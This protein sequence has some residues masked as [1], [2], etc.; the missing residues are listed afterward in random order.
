MGTLA[1]TCGKQRDNTQAFPERHLETARIAIA[2]ACMVLALC[3]GVSN[4]AWGAVHKM[5]AREL[6]HAFAGRKN[7]TRGIS[8]TA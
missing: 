1:N 7:R 5:T 2:L 6:P 8:C 3:A 4:T